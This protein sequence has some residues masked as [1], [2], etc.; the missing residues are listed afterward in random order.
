MSKFWTVGFE[1]RRDPE[2]RSLTLAEREEIRDACVTLGAVSA[3]VWADG[4]LYLLRMVLPNGHEDPVDRFGYA[5]SLGGELM[6]KFGLPWEPHRVEMV[7]GDR[8]TSPW[9]SLALDVANEGQLGFWMPE[10]ME[11]EIRASEDVHAGRVTRHDSL[12][13]MLDHLG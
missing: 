2:L 1:F 9:L 11:R 12:E 6:E 13:E 4:D 7:E 8:L 10:V 5:W 3:F